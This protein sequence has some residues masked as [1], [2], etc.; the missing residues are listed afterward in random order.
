MSSADQLISV[1]SDV[2]SADQLISIGS[3]VS[4]TGPWEL[5]CLSSTELELYGAIIVPPVYCLS[6]TGLE[7]YGAIIYCLSSIVFH[8]LSSIVFH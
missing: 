6:V 4:V 3:D 1:G 7:L 2:S 8:C 5:C